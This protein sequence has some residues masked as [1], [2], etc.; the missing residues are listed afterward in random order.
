M[1]NSRKSEP[2][3]LQAGLGHLAASLAAF[4]AIGTGGALAAVALGDPGD[5]S[6]RVEVALFETP[7]TEAVYLKSRSDGG[8]L[9]NHAEEPTLG[10][11]YDPEA[12][13][14]APVNVTIT[15]LADAAPTQ[16]RITLPKAPLLGFFE[17]TAA[18]DLPRIASDGRTPAEAYARPFAGGTAP[19]ISLVVGGLGLNATHTLAAINELPA[20]VTLSFVPYS[21]NLQTWINRARAAGHEVLLEVPME[22]YDYPNVDTGPQTLLT[23]VSADENLRRLNILLGKATGY[24]GVTNYQGA[25]FATDGRAASPVLKALKARGLVFVHDGGTVRSDLPATAEAAGLPFESADRILDADPSADSIDRQLLELEALA[26]QNGSA[27]GVGFA[28]PVTIE[29]LRLWAF[30]LKAKGYDL[31]PASHAVGVTAITPDKG[32]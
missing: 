7:H 12:D 29:Q 13:A 20:E 10:V 5:A 27:L 8:G 6:P 23:S 2:S 22:P 9:I 31:V 32:A 4:G 3:A 17:K 18:G 24:F 1:S 30:G 16:T 28:Y 19:R 25:K 26:L 21:S 15:D 11:E 14:A